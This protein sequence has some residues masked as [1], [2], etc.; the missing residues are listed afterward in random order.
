M[1]QH[2]TQACVIRDRLLEE[3]RNKNINLD[4]ITNRLYNIQPPEWL[5]HQIMDMVRHNQYKRIT[6]PV[7][8][9]M[10]KA[11]NMMIIDEITKD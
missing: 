11:V 8:L 1:Q 7:E 2:G 9:A 3:R 4:Q 5:R 10:E 6:C